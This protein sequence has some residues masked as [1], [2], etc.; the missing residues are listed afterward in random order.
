MYMIGVQEYG[1]SSSRNT[2]SSSS[3]STCQDYNSIGVYAVVQY[4]MSTVTIVTT[5]A[6]GV[7]AGVNAVGVK[8]LTLVS[9]VVCY[10]E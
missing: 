2:Q 10:C 4:A 8:V 6:T 1:S 5:V 9:T 7:V 3:R